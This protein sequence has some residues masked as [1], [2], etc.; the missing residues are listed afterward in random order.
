VGL[1]DV[2]ARARNATL[3]KFV[4]T[5][6]RRWF[7]NQQLTYKNIQP[8]IFNPVTFQ[9]SNKIERL[10]LALLN[11][12]HALAPKTVDWQTVATQL[13]QAQV[14]SRK[15]SNLNLFISKLNDIMFQKGGYAFLN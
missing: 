10:S 5:C 3:F 11:G 12:L 14:E 9:P 7:D 6:L 2:W 1:R 4:Y 15:E 8:A 13:T